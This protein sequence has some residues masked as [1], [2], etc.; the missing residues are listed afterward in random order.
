MA[1]SKIKDLYRETYGK[2]VKYIVDGNPD[3]SSDHEVLRRKYED[4][5]RVLLKRILVKVDFEL[6][7]KHPLIKIK[8]AIIQCNSVH[9]KV[10]SRLRIPWNLD[11]D[12]YLKYRDSVHGKIDAEI[13]CLH[14]DR[15]THILTEILLR[16]K[17]D[18]MQKSAGESRN[19]WVGFLIRNGGTNKQLEE[20]AKNTGCYLRYVK[21]DE[22]WNKKSNY[23]VGLKAFSNVIRRHLEEWRKKNIGDAMVPLGEEYPLG[24]K[25]PCVTERVFTWFANHKEAKNAFYLADLVNS[26]QL[27]GISAELEINDK[28]KI[29]DIRDF[30]KDCQ[31]MM[32]RYVF[33]LIHQAEKTYSGEGP[34]YPDAYFSYTEAKKNGKKVKKYGMIESLICQFTPYASS[35]DGDGKINERYKNCKFNNMRV[36]ED[37]FRKIRVHFEITKGEM[38]KYAIGYKKHAYEVACTVA[39]IMDVLFYDKPGSVS[40]ETTI[41]Q[42]SSG[43]E[44]IDSRLEKVGVPF[45]FRQL[46]KG[47]S[48]EDQLFLIPQYR[49]H[50][51]HSFY[52]FAFGVSLMSYAPAKVI[53][54][55]IR[56]NKLNDEKDVKKLLKKWFM[57][58]MWHDIA[59]MIEKGNLV[60]EQHILSLMQGGRREKGLLPWLPSLGNLM[61]VDGL[62]DEIRKL[63]EGSIKICP[64]LK[65]NISKK[66]DACAKR[67]KLTKKE[68]E[69]LK[70]ENDNRLKKLPED[71]V[72]AAAFERRDHGVWSAMM[73]NHAWDQ[74]MTKLYFGRSNVGKKRQDV[75]LREIAKAIIPHHL[76][77]W[78]V[79]G[80]L[81]DYDFIKGLPAECTSKQT[82]DRFSKHC[83]VPSEPASPV[84]CYGKMCVGKTVITMPHEA[85]ELGYLLGICDMISQAGRENTELPPETSS[86][87]GIKYQEFEIKNGILSLLL[88][89][90][91]KS[92]TRE[93]FCKRYVL[94][95]LFLGLTVD[96]NA[97]PNSIR[98][99]ITPDSP[100]DNVFGY[101]YNSPIKKRGR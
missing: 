99:A 53:P 6:A 98:I 30:L 18:S 25:F 3:S 45:L 49:E 5:L 78:D 71:I 13:L 76:A 9:P 58:S 32:N 40:I 43:L 83:L 47:L 48:K 4:K 12:E 89:Y 57:V 91:K 1:K 61:Q 85:N 56:F 38:G 42:C 62:L 33:S 67:D 52:V 46:F 90:T 31:W 55:S 92:V 29:D 73:L 20:A 84:E 94:P 69:K 24:E 36:I 75:L 64:V 44:E 96:S 17:S 8:T 100:G 88:Q 80:M 34:S 26:E 21:W 66:I 23:K 74:D 39:G 81:G 59:Y 63:S 28:A 97:Y 60:L 41:R 35:S 72:I 93:L 37:L 15:P 11:K 101:F 82:M 19:D 77:D 70:K 95:S 68:K 27:A 14:P 2:L 79:R 65:K 7:Q 22:K 16:L 87:L 50:F 54:T 10:N 86:K 51:I